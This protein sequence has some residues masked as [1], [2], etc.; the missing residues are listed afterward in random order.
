MCYFCF[1]LQQKSSFY[2]VLVGGWSFSIYAIQFVFRNLSIILQEHWHV[3]LGRHLNTNS[4]EKWN[5]Q[6]RLIHIRPVLCVCVCVAGYLGL[7]G[8]FSFAVC[9]R[10]GPLVDRK[11]INIL[12]WTLQLFGLL[13]IYLGIQIQPVAFAIIMSALATKTLEYPISLG[14]AAWRWVL[15]NPRLG[16]KYWF[17][18]FE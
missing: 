1:S 7:V 18:Q 3:A 9:Y 14:A 8:F 12:S 11:S 6:Q 5:R 10:Y 13:L 2:L 4:V 15:N 16:I 17:K